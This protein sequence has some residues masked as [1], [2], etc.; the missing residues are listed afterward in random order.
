MGQQCS[1]LYP[2]NRPNPKDPN[3]NHCTEFALTLE[4]LKTK[5]N[6][7]QAVVD[8]PH[9]CNDE[10]SNPNLVEGFNPLA[11]L[12]QN[13]PDKYERD[14][15]A[16]IVIPN[17]AKMLNN[18]G[19]TFN[20]QNFDVWKILSGQELNIQTYIAYATLGSSPTLNITKLFNGLLKAPAGIISSGLKKLLSKFL[21]SS[22]ATQ[23]ISTLGVLGAGVARTLVTK[24][25]KTLA[26]KSYQ[27]AAEFYGKMKAKFENTDPTE[28][29]QTP[30]E[31]T[32]P[33]FDPDA[34]PVE[35]EEALEAPAEDAG[36]DAG[37]DAAEEG[38]E[39]AAEAS[40]DAVPGLGEVFMAAQVLISAGEA[41]AKAIGETTIKY[42]TA[43]CNNIGDAYEGDKPVD[44]E[45]TVYGY[46]EG[47]CH[48]NDR[49][50]GFSVATSCGCCKT[51][52]SIIGKGINC[53]R[54]N[55]RADPFVC[56]L[57]D[58]SCNKNNEDNCFQTPARQRT[59]HPLYRDLSQQT[60]RDKVFDYCSGELLLPGQTDWLEMWLADSIVNINSSMAVS[61]LTVRA[62]HYNP[63]SS[64]NERGLHNPINQ[65]QPC[66]R[67]IARA[68]SS[69]KHCTWEALK[70]V[71]VVEG[72][73]NTAGFLWS[74]NL[75]ETIVK[76]YTG[77]GGSFLGGINTDGVNRNG[78]F[79]NTLWEICNQIP[80]LCTDI[81]T[82]NC[83]NYT[84]QQ[85]AT[86]PFLFPWCS[87]YLPSEQYE[88][89]SDLGV[90]K[91]CTPLC[92]QTGVIPAVESTGR[93]LNCLST[94]CVIDNTTIDLINTKFADS[95]SINLNQ[96]CGSCG[97]SNVSETY[98]FGNVST[99]STDK[100]NAFTITPEKSY[101]N[102]TYA[103]V[104]GSFPATPNQIESVMIPVDNAS[105]IIEN[106][107]GVQSVSST[108]ISDYP[109]CTLYIGA[110]GSG[111]KAALDTVK[112]GIRFFRGKSPISEK[113]GKTG[114][115]SGII[116]RITGADS[117]KN[118]ISPGNYIVGFSTIDGHKLFTGKDKYATVT[119]V[120]SKYSGNIETSKTS[121]IYAQQNDNV[122]LNQCQ[123]ISSGF[124][125][126][127][128]E[129]KISG[130][131]N[132]T[133]QCG[134]ATCYSNQ[135]GKKV[136]IPC[137]ST[138]SSVSAI[139]TIENLQNETIQQIKIKKFFN[140][141]FS[142]F[143]L[144]LITFIFLLIFFF[145]KS[146]FRFINDLLGM[147]KVSN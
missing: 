146:T 34:E 110:Q 45:W 77:G 100:S 131:I 31:Y 44:T 2:T 114:V 123:C 42:E 144:F 132:F 10:G 62:G 28:L 121:N 43:Y 95:A 20:D 30:D 125:L 29:K 78:S 33:E 92:N 32:N 81:L 90:E 113:G 25:L 94:V 105:L 128:A 37:V 16:T 56:C 106:S 5:K 21:S 103:G 134:E 7:D 142:I 138:T 127:A 71:S 11:G 22:H 38:A 83:S 112:D 139:Q 4:D 52:C 124:N 19:N 115:V 58:Y 9:Y 50:R 60:C 55:F 3:N 98:S 141:F 84:A 40:A 147:Y 12:A 79:Y 49:H 104:L 107:T 61:N 69:G 102:N 72:N 87:C 18:S 63:S 116:T 91:Q 135:N 15:Y 97:S 41:I 119:V 57:L 24:L 8:V 101:P 47:H 76:K 65:K 137:S 59:C 1:K 27:K 64:V 86:S 51:A 111:S 35:G 54:Q 96:V 136:P 23:V 14:L 89:Y 39:V 140:M 133:Q 46:S 118:K 67:A 36:V 48:F 74:K 82:E 6:L 80:S 26:N 85:V 108:T 75:L 17:D 145:T 99:N 130:K 13:D 117:V 120:E 129:S 66:L 53:I 73:V 122:S 93:T 126:V 70:N 88:Q 68:V 109:Q 143:G